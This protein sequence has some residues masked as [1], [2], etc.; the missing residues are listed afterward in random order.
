MAK[1]FPLTKAGTRLLYKVRHHRGHGIHSPFVFSF[2]TKVIEEKSEYNAYDDVRAYLKSCPNVSFSENKTHRLLF[3]IV[4]YFKLK[5]I[6][7][8]GGGEGITTLYLTVA[9]SDIECVSL[10]Q[11]VDRYDNA[12][13]IYG[14]WNR[15]VLQSKD[16]ISTIEEKKD[17]IFVSLKNYIFSQNEFVLDLLR[18][19]HQDSVIIID[20]I[21]TNRKRQALWKMLIQ[22]NE[23]VVSL[24]LFHVGILFFDK[25][26]YKRNF[27][28]SF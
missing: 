7:E 12:Q 14:G 27:K 8:L 5:S 19:V 3:K 21:R 28:L 24:D 10:Q 22:Q 6:L 13:F 17:C 9:S 26:Y 4:N 23:V 2:I 15:N 16:D 1:I 25:K 18:L 20:G 11:G